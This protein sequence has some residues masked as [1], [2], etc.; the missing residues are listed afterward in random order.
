[1]ALLNYYATETP[2]LAESRG[3]PHPRHPRT[4]APLPVQALAGTRSFAASH[5]A[6][7]PASSKRSHPS[8]TTPRELPAA[9]ADIRSIRTV[10][11]SRSRR[12][13]VSDRKSV[14]EGNS[15]DL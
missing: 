1:M 8:R 6:A 3:S 2:P 14:V 4:P 12:A 7:Y 9:P 15:V 5:T 13:P 11:L 10:L